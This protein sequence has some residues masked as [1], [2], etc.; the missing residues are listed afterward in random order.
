M[1]K[2]ARLNKLNILY[3]YRI[4]I[5]KKKNEGGVI[6]TCGVGGGREGIA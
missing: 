5:I 1:C 4:I 6:I 2:V 3:E